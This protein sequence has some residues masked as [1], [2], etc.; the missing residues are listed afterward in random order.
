[1]HICPTC[2]AEFKGDV[3][4]CPHCAQRSHSSKKPKRL[5]SNSY[6]TLS[7]LN[8]SEGARAIYDR[9]IDVESSDAKNDT[10]QVGHEI[11]SSGGVYEKFITGE[12]SSS[13][14]DESS[15]KSEAPPDTLSSRLHTKVENSP[16]VGPDIIALSC[17]SCG[18]KLQITSDIDRFACMHCGTESL[19]K[20]GDVDHF[21]PWS[22][23]SNDNGYNLVV[24][25]RACNQAKSNHLAAL[26]FLSKWYERNLS[27]PDNFESEMNSASILCDL[28]ASLSV[29]EWAYSSIEST[30]ESVWCGG[31]E[32]EAL[33]C[34]WRGVIGG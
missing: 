2:F 31:R 29:A 13:L 21:I 9:K 20:R 4:E 23:Y 10:V 7:K 24:A 8:Q 18:G 16:V 15:G 22:K 26:P 5:E 30:G 1:M 19:V 27:L 12:S 6:S 17:P 28:E 11:A 32:F 3:E 33:P 14:T 25:S 34:G